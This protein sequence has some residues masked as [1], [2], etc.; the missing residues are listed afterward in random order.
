MKKCIIGI[1]C[2]LVLFSCKNPYEEFQKAVEQ[3]AQDQVA[4]TTQE[5]IDKNVAKIFGSID[6]NH[7]WNSITQGSVSITADADL[8]DIVKVQVLTESPF[9]NEDAKVLNETNASKGQ[10]VTLSYEA[11]SYYDHLVA[12]CVNSRGMYYIQ[13]F[14]INDSHVNFAEAQKTR[15]MTRG[16][17]SFPE[18]STLKLGSPKQSFNA[19][20]AEK[21]Y[22]VWAE[23]SGQDMINDRL[24][25]VTGSGDIG[26]GWNIEL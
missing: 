26:S 16:E 22:G 8:D 3:Q 20:R 11:P 21:K 12:A 19:M 1:A 24:W 18:L 6:P 23:E 13:V 14:D 17:G 25:E 5:D 7:T 10:T 4:N 2:A 9:F 15:S